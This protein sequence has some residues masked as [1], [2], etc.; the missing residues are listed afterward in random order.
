MLRVALRPSRALATILVAAHLAA[1]GAVVPLE[2]PIGAK[3]ALGALAATSLVH[4]LRRYAFLKGRTAARALELRSADEASLQTG[5][6]TW[7]D[8]RILTT[9]Y[10][11]ARLGVVNLKV[12]GALLPRHVVILPDALDAEDFRRLRVRLRWGYR[13]GR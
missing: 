8:A 10:V 11:S 7:H 5:D 2:L 12:R 6:G 9:T 13:A 4:A 1:A 3:L